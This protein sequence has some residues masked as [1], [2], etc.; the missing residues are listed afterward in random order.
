M[1]QAV[2]SPIGTPIASNAAVEDL[3]SHETLPESVYLAGDPSFPKVLRRRLDRYFADQNLS[4]KANSAMWIKIGVGL[5]VLAGSW[6]AIYAIHPATPSFLAL[7]LLGGLAQTFLL[8]NIAHD[9]NHNA[10]S[11][12]ATVNK[13]LNYV[14]DVCGINS[15]MW[16]ILHHRGHH[17]CVNVHGEDDALTGRGLLRF[18]PHEPLRPLQRF[19]H[20]YALFLYAVFSL[21]YVFV[22]DFECFFK[23]EH[24]YLTRTRHPA[25]EYVILFAGK[26]FYLTYMLVLPVLL[27]HMPMLVVAGA[28]L[29]VHLI[30]GLSVALV[31]QTTHTVDSTYFP[32]GRN[33]FENGVYHIFATTADY[34]TTSP[35][36]GWL[37]GG[38]NHHVVHHLCPF[39]CHTHYAPLTKI[40]KETAAE[41]NVPYRQH[42]TMTRAIWHHLILLKQLGDGTWS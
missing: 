35:M 12:T 32:E 18:T 1:S 6:V 17:S 42:P 33:E 13:A 21:D 16:R 27:L 31:F 11:S 10:I 14:F 3:V 2:T 24:D 29:M 39:V 4:P 34:A 23:P 30:V 19:Q 20:I 9:S 38:L 36:V 28:F 5:A 7:Y 22:R 26:A 8:L 41:F 25:R 37:T 40:V 15:Y